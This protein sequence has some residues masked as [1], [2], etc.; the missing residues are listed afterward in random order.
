MK[1]NKNTD[2]ETNKISL[3][4]WIY[5]FSILF[6]VFIT[7]RAFFHGQYSVFNLMEDK[8]KYKQKELELVELEKKIEKTEKE[9]S[10][11]KKR[12]PFEME[13]KARQNNMTKP[14]EK[15]YKYNVIKEKNNNTDLDNN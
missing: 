11:L 10:L 12:D 3:K 5:T 8:V 2:K 6:V 7:Y 13:K 14:G 4:T 1:T 9:L 15:V